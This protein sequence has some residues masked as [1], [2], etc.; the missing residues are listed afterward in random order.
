MRALTV[1]ASVI[2]ANITVV[3]INGSMGASYY[4]YTQ[5]NRAGIGII[6]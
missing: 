6:T 4:C 3:A 1:N 5:V 2:R